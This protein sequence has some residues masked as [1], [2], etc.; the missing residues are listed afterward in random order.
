ML[1]RTLVIS[2]VVTL[3]CAVLAVP[4]AQAIVSAPPT[5][6]RILFALVLF[7][8]WSSL[9]VRTIIWII[10]L[11]KT[12]PVNAAIVFLGTRDNLIPVATVERFQAKMKAA[13]VRC[14]AVFYDGQPHGFFNDAPWKSRTLIEADKFLASLGWIQGPPT[15]KEPADAG[16]SP[17]A[18]K[19]KKKRAGN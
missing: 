6:S 1:A 5:L 3:L 16:N 12:G 14:E 11:Q 7:P 8:L 18:T 13:G 19:K 15:F 10:V 4:L 2:A 9:L 17:A